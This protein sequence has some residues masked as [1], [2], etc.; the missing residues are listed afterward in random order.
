[1]RLNLMRL[2]QKTLGWVVIAYAG[3]QWMSLLQVETV[4]V[5]LIVNRR[6]PGAW[7]ESVGAVIWLGLLIGGIGLVRRRA[8]GRWM[9]V[10]AGATTIGVSLVFL[11]RAVM[12]A[13]PE[14]S[15]PLPLLV[16]ELLKVLPPLFILVA[17][18]RLQSADA[19][20]FPLRDSSRVTPKP[21]ASHAELRSLDRAYGMFSWIAI[22][23][24]AASVASRLHVDMA[25]A[26]VLGMLI[27]VPVAL[28]TLASVVA[29]FVY[30][31]KIFH[32]WPLPVMSMLV[33]SM[34]VAAGYGSA[35]SGRVRLL[36]IWFVIATATL[37]LFCV[38]W[39]GFLRRRR[40]REAS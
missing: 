12:R 32:E 39:Y 33:V 29:G 31:I 6:L 40:M 1:M 23:S 2:G 5:G 25:T 35:V 27:G 16:V 37:L 18:L 34:L 8:W 21:A 28:A 9:V 20:E 15:V 36:E 10:T 30:S 38:R 13:S 24:T 3:L 14:A 26:Q 17:A 22:V 4:V 7:D 11:I 19:G